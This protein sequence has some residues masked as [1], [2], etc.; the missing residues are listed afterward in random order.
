MSGMLLRSI[1]FPADSRL[2]EVNPGAVFQLIAARG[3][4][5]ALDIYDDRRIVGHLSV[6][7]T[8][9]PNSTPARTHFNLNAQINLDSALL[10]GT[11]LDLN[12]QMYLDREGNPQSWLLSLAT[13]KP[14]L[15]LVLA[16]TSPEAA[17]SVLLKQNG[18][19]L[20]DSSSLKPGK[21]EANPLVALLLGTLGVSYADFQA[22]RAEAEVKAEGIRIEARQGKFEL[23]DSTRQGFIL[24]IG[25]PG[26]PGFRMC[27]DNTGEIVRL[28]TPVSYHL[29]TE[30]V[31][32]DPDQP[33]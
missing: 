12:C 32:P 20:L 17:P 14:K 16:Q 26:K 3:E 30:S 18:Q 27:V 2:A 13:L 10:P 22:I 21:P 5:S 4:S 29:M 6:M 23:G 24:K 1:W 15:N 31:R 25:T 7:A 8:P 28:E 9:V 33:R 19:V 11:K